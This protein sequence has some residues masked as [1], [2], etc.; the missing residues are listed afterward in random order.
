VKTV[1]RIGLA[2]M[3][4]LALTAIG[5]VASA[6]ASSGFLPSAVPASFE[7]SPT[8]GFN[9]NV[10][11]WPDGTTC[12]MPLKLRDAD[13]ASPPSPTT[14]M[15]PSTTTGRTCSLRAWGGD[16]TLVMNGCDFI[17]NPG[18]G[19]FDI[20]PAGCGPIRLDWLFCSMSIYPKSGLSATYQNKGGGSTVQVD[21]AAQGLRTERSGGCGSATGSIDYYAQWTITAKDQLSTPTNVQVASI[22]GIYLAGAGAA[23]VA[24][25]PR[26]EA[27]SYTKQIAGAGI[28]R[29]ANVAGSVVCS[30][31]SLAGALSAPN[32]ALSLDATYASCMGNGTYPSLVD[33]NS[34]NYVVSASNA[35]PP[36]SGTLGIACDTPG[37]VIEFNS[38]SG[39]GFRVLVCSSK[40]SPQS[41]LGSIALSHLYDSTAKKT[42]IALGVNVSGVKYEI[43][44]PC[45]S[46]TE[47]RTDGVLSGS[48]SLFGV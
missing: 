21:A 7:G 35:G 4:A 5:G 31:A 42:G 48:G 23:V 1:K 33:M 14:R 13:G 9:I 30:S 18:R 44:G 26:F 27:D 46:R 15:V 19:S 16:A 41:G 29:F 43:S 10:L 47:I 22:P 3:A 20:G 45:V 40:L 17:L 32:A 11:K 2:A 39:T 38:Y 12:E 24:D 34:C 28:N 6:S 8:A 25:Q 36:Y 37:D